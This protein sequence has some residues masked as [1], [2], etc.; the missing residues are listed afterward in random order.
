M[1]RVPH[2]SDDD[3]EALPGV[4]LAQLAAGEEMSVQH[5]TIEPGAEVPIHSH[6]HEQSGYIAEG[7]LT[8]LLEDGEELA[9]EAGDSYDLAGGET[10]G[11]VN[12]G[13]ETVRGVDVFSPPRRN[14][15]WAR[16]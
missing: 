3:V 7:T 2:E 14:P 13:D 15:D 4:H 16:D 9:C 12:R 11:A 8:F 1:D 6:P 5:F 10:H